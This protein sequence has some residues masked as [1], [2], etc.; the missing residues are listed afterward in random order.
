MQSYQYNHMAVRS[1][2]KENANNVTHLCEFI[3][4]GEY[5]SVF[6]IFIKRYINLKYYY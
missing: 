3:V 5:T 2:L 4:L 6:E 1:G